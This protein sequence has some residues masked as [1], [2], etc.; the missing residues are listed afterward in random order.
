MIPNGT[1]TPAADLLQCLALLRVSLLPGVRR[2]SAAY[3]EIGIVLTT[4]FRLQG[5]LFYFSPFSP[6]FLF[7][8]LLPGAVSYFVSQLTDTAHRSRLPLALFH[9]RFVCV[10]LGCS[11]SDFLVCFVLSSRTRYVDISR[12]ILHHL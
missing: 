6:L 7:L 5:V 11:C 8:L 3:Q 2:T 9:F 4:M 12:I 10:Y 1:E